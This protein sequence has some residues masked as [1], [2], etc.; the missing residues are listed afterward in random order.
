VDAEH[1]FALDYQTIATARDKPTW[2]SLI[3]AFTCLASSRKYSRIAMSNDQHLLHSGPELRGSFVFPQ[4]SQTVQHRF[5]YYHSSL[6]HIGA[7][8]ILI[9]LMKLL[10]Y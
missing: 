1:P 8:I 4:P 9:T 2:T 10:Y 3:A 7:C 6:N 5:R